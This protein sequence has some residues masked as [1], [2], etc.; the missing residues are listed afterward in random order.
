MFPET[1]KKGLGIRRKIIFLCGILVLVVFVLH[2]MLDYGFY[3]S[4]GKELRLRNFN[5][6]H[7]AFLLFL[8]IKNPILRLWSA[9]ISD[10]GMVWIFT[11]RKKSL[12]L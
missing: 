10:M 1:L 12:V 2:T 3:D 8:R 6:A 5:Q 7:G 4:Q 11:R 9:R